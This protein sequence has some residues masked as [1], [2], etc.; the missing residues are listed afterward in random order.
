MSALGT[1]LSQPALFHAAESVGGVCLDFL[2]AVP[3]L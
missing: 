3:A 1:T 2:A